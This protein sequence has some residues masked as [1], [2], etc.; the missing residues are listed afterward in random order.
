MEVSLTCHAAT[1]F[2]FPRCLTERNSTTTRSYM[3]FFA[4]SR[5]CRPRPLAVLH[6]VAR[7]RRPLFSSCPSCTAT[8]S[9]ATSARDSSSSTSSCSYSKYIPPSHRPQTVEHV[10]TLPDMLQVTLLH[11]RRRQMLATHYHHLIKHST[12]SSVLFYLPPHPLQQRLPQ[13]PSHRMH[14]LPLFTHHA[15]TSHISMSSP[16]LVGITFGCFVIHRMSF[17][18]WMKQTRPKWC[19]HG[20]LG[21]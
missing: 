12:L 11:H 19:D 8:R 16:T 7:A 18:I 4:A 3:S 20:H 21:V 13:H 5:P 14:L 2:I 6:C 17:G 9:Q 10:V 1:Y 15:Y